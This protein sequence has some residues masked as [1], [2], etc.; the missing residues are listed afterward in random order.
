MVTWVIDAPTAS[1]PAL[2]PNMSASAAIVLLAVT[3][4]PPLAVT[5]AF[6]PIK[7]CTCGWTST[8]EKLTLVAPMPAVT[9]MVSEC[10][11]IVDCAATSSEEIDD[12][13]APPSTEA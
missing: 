9:A 12:S 13:V 5:C 3:A 8:N 6:G 10:G 11:V 1:P 7:A 2:T 4:T